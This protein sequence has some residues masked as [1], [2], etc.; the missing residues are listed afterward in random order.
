MYKAIEA[1][2]EGK[3]DAVLSAG[4]SGVFVALS[5]ILLKPIEGIKKIGF[6]PTIPTISKSHR[7]LL[8][9]DS[10]ANKE[11][12]AT[13]LENFAL[14]STIY[15]REIMKIEKPAVGVVNIGSEDNKGFLFQ[16]EANNLLKINNKVNYQG[17]VEPRD[18]LSSNCDI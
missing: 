16:I 8:L 17:F 18:V 9:C 10:G 15:C 5:Y 4:N 13:D 7:H 3:A 14:M 12:D 2:A 1:V 6:M 11:C